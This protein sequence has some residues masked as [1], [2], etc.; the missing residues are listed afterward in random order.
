MR[1]SLIHIAFSIHSLLMI[2]YYQCPIR[3]LLILKYFS[4][5]VFRGILNQKYSTHSLEPVLLFTCTLPLHGYSC[6]E[7]HQTKLLQAISCSSHLNT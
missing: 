4:V 3:M 7:E 5:G 6:A 2:F 1:H